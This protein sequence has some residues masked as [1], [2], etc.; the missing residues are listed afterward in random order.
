MI[1]KK[2]MQP[3]DSFRHSNTYMSHYWRCLACYWEAEAAVCVM[4]ASLQEYLNFAELNEITSVRKSFTSIE[5]M[6][7]IGKVYHPPT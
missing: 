7:L 2:H 4:A 3:Y 5:F 1:D 6:R